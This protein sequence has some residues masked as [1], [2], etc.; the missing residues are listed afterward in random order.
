MFDASAK[1]ET[2]DPQDW[3]IL[4]SLAHR[5]VDDMLT[6]LE[7]VRDRP[8]WEPTPPEVK[9]FLSTPLPRD[10]LG[11]E[12]AYQEYLQYI[13]PLSMGNIHPRFWSWVIGTGSPLGALAEMLAAGMNPNVGGGDQ[14]ASY[15]ELQV[16]D[17]CKE[18]LAYPL[19]AS[20]LLVSGGSM[21]NLVGLTV[22]RNTQAGFD[23]RKEGVAAAAKPMVLY[24][25]REVHSSVQKVVELLGLGAQALHL[26]PVDQHYRIQVAEL[27]SAVQ[28]DRSAGLQPFC[29][30]G[31]AG[32]VNTGAFDDLNALADLCQREEMWF[33]VDGAFG[34]LAA[35]SPRLQ[36]L[37]SGMSHADSLAF[38]L[39]K[40]MYMPYEVG[41][42]LVRS[43]TAH[44]RAFS[45]TPEYLEHNTRGLAAGK[46]W[47][48]DYGV[49]LSRGFRALKVWL[50][51]KAEGIEKFTRLIEQNVEQARYLASLVDQTPE[52]ER[53][54][55]VPLNIVCFR[56]RGD[57]LD[58]E[59]LNALNRELL[60]R[61]HES[62]IAAPSYTTLNG[63]YALRVCITNHRSQRAD[64]NL[65]VE[66]VLRLG[67]EL[68]MEK[69]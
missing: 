51:I 40:W 27:E 28:A 21:A 3:G 10:G 23:I 24:A 61:L 48:S 65:L 53:L 49:Q 22:A 59:T 15:V 56:F 46:I 60:L 52:L 35:L 2:L 63:K 45:L 44:R 66:Q 11:E 57:S 55:P 36:Y 7:T 16:L 5:M 67:K 43:E 47:L 42:A 9:D 19:D 34:A 68:L 1:E 13:H 54:A 26:I 39:H 25:S 12:A 6:N 30:V 18:M 20:G 69:K 8:V 50:S 29:V 4:R 31:N 41:C 33:H 17:W 62:G 37:T 64:F 38:D 58:E 32:T 14:V